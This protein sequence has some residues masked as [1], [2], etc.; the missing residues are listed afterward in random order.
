MDHFLAINPLD[1]PS[2]PLLEK[3]KLPQVSAIYFAIAKSGEILYIGRS[4]N[5]ANKWLGH[6]RYLE[7][8]EIGNVRIAWLSCNDE[9]LLPQIEEAMIKHFLPCLNH[10][11]IKQS[12]TKLDKPYVD[13]LS[14]ITRQA[15]GSMSQRAFAK[16]LGVSYTTVQAWERGVSI[17][18]IQNLAKIAQRAE[19][20]IEELFGDLGIKPASEPSEP[21]D[22][23][24]ILRQLN[25]MPLTDVAQIVQAGVDRL[26][27]AVESKGSE[28]KAS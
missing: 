23:A 25:K 21:S 7:L 10:T 6:H 5:I 17:P 3:H 20:S 18:D 28:A 11:L 2:V 16:F 8:K 27:A 15:R 4:I 24:V 26:A 22:L 19:Y 14:K 12:K 9:S 1:L 13:K